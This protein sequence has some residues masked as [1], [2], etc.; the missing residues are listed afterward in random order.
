MNELD[1]KYAKVLDDIK[2]QLQAS[3][4]LAVYLEEE[5]EDLYTALKDKF[6]PSLEELHNQVAQN[7]PLQLEALEESFLDEEL[8]GMFLP[9]ILGYSVLRGAFNED[10]KYI[11]PQEHFKKILLSICNSSNFEILSNRIGQT[12]EVGFA[13][14]SDIWITN[15]IAEIDNKFVK[16]FLL[17]LKHAKYRDIRSRHTSYKKYAKQFKSFNFLTA[18]LPATSSEVKIEYKSI[19]NFLMYRGGLG[20]A[21]GD[22]V[23]KYLTGIISNE[24]LASSL[25]HLEILMILGFYFDLK[26]GERNLLAERLG[27]YKNFEEE[28]ES[29]FTI[30]RKL[31]DVENGVSDEDYV[32]MNNVVQ[33]TS[34]TIFKEYLST[35]TNIDSIG[36]INSDAIDMARNYHNN[37]KGLSPQN[38]C[39]RNAIFSKFRTFLGSLE[40]ED[41]NDYFELNKVFTTYMNAFDNEQFNQNVKGISMSYVKKLLRRFTE[42]RSKDYQDIKKF[43]SAVF[44]DLGFL[45]EKEIKELFKTKRKKTV[46]S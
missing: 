46:A 40:P 45:K 3:D 4:E 6:E 1:Q 18:A 12:V 9:R 2:E 23:Y 5:D 25:E 17:G 27:D 7:D 37:N 20:S 13:L 43:V 10:F 35:I 26:D 34:S 14:S 33:A 11:R 38:D 41:F 44:L 24:K 30:L 29:Y 31:Q 21:T 42:K 19:V 32:R 15:L 22:S 16:S 28:E 8:E 36:Y 39:L